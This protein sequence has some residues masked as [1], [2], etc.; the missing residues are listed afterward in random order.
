[1]A[2]A[3]PRIIDIDATSVEREEATQGLPQRDRVETTHTKESESAVRKSIQKVGGLF[4]T[5]ADAWSKVLREI[6]DSSGVGS[7]GRA[8]CVQT[9]MQEVNEKVA[10]KQGGIVLGLLPKSLAAVLSELDRDQS[11]E[12]TPEEVASAI[13]LMKQKKRTWRR[14]AIGLACVLLLVFCCFSVVNF[15]LVS[16]AFDLAKE[17]RA[18]ND[19][20]LR[21]GNGVEHAL[22]GSSETQLLP[23]GRLVPRTANQVHN[24][25]SGTCRRLQ[26]GGEVEVDEVLTRNAPA[27][28]RRLTSVVPDQYLAEMK[29][30]QL[31]L[32]A[33]NETE[34]VL[35]HLEIHGFVR[36]LDAGS[37]CGS[38][39]HLR[40]EWGEITLD[41]T[42]V[43]L[44]FEFRKR[45]EEF[46][47]FLPV[48]NVVAS[49]T[50]RRLQQG[51][52][53]VGLFN[54][55]MDYEWNCESTAKPLENLQP[56]YSFTI[57]TLVWCGSSCRSTHFNATLPGYT[58][59]PSTSEWS[60]IEIVERVVATDTEMVSKQTL[61]NL[62]GV[63]IHSHTNF[64]A[65]QRTTV[66]TFT[67]HTLSCVNDTD[68]GVLTFKD[69]DKWAIAALGRTEFNGEWF[70]VFNVFLKDDN[71]KE[72]VR[73]L[74]TVELWEHS[75]TM[76]PYK[77]YMPH[78][79]EGTSISYFTEFSKD[80]DAEELLTLK[81]DILDDCAR[82]PEVNSTLSKLGGV[83]VLDE[84]LPV[85]LLYQE[86]FD[87]GMLEVPQDRYW[88]AVVDDARLRAGRRLA[89]SHRRRASIREKN[90]LVSATDIANCPLIFE[91]GPFNMKF[92]EQEEVAVGG[93]RIRDIF[94]TA[95]G[96]VD[97]NFGPV[98]VSIGGQ[99]T[100]KTR[101]KVGADHCYGAGE[102]ELDVS[103][104]VGIGSL[105][106]AQVGGKGKLEA[107]IPTQTEFE[108]KTSEFKIVGSLT[109]YGSVDVFGMIQIQIPA[110]AH[111]VFCFPGI[112]VTL[113]RLGPVPIDNPTNRGDDT[114]SIAAK[115]T[116]EVN[117]FFFKFTVSVPITVMP[118]TTLW[119]ATPDMY[120]E[121]P[122]FTKDCQLVERTYDRCSAG[123][124]WLPDTYDENT[125]A[126]QPHVR[127]GA[128]AYPLVSTSA[129]RDFRWYCYGNEEWVRFPRPVNKIVAQLE[130][131]DRRIIWVGLVCDRFLE[132][133]ERWHYSGR[134][135]D[136]CRESIH[137]STTRG[138]INVHKWHNA[139]IHTGRFSENGFD[140][141][142][143]GNSRRR[144]YGHGQHYSGCGKHTVV[145]VRWQDRRRS[146]AVRWECWDYLGLPRQFSA[147]CM[148]SSHVARLF[149][150]KGVPDVGSDRECSAL[151]AADTNCWY[152]TWYPSGSCFFSNEHQ[153]AYSIQWGVRFGR[154]S[155]N[156]E[157]TLYDWKIQPGQTVTFQMPE[158]LAN[159]QVTVSTQGL[160]RSDT[161][162]LEPCYND[163]SG[164]TYQSQC[165]GSGTRVVL[166]LYSSSRSGEGKI[167]IKQAIVR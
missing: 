148:I 163:D 31:Q 20:V 63:E 6:S 107:E 1:M 116:V 37:Q 153:S 58:L 56:P 53:I 47:G 98:T 122:W 121:Q 144:G 38:V 54:F 95:G 124:I 104:G 140:W 71:V 24:C 55:I 84:K 128:E 92:C 76:K 35:Q 100:A 127:K 101:C 96:S 159:K 9:M 49:G 61:P 65:G 167:S 14:L 21:V 145:K 132:P 23:D 34:P 90:E 93:D 8:Q 29:G 161:V 109:P 117:F 51:S 46:F 120:G 160:S 147:E 87:A 68:D 80:V 86:L 105:I 108:G 40:T 156:C 7:D 27:K 146:G 94:V 164:G 103:I 36:K 112:E 142:C 125:G 60:Y 151:C 15:F 59:D 118:E 89:A 67:N 99:G 154:P 66:K 113:D 149:S 158:S 17:V 32:R 141:W 82:P 85:V 22:V 78:Q 3:A 52:S 165:S 42:D 72:Q 10:S 129:R 11:G 157:A 48:D 91:T 136:D 16:Y 25:S 131:N 106:N 44:S 81:E 19:G 97:A 166:K 28:E 79:L 137:V 135:D 57:R 74:A 143:N 111:G 114:I 88:K 64:A 30:I 133:H 12:I 119:S 39:V 123:H 83:S 102:V 2:Q 62:P 75:E 110:C 115:W 162:I 130:N 70:R 155:Y 150:Y 41:D 26:D 73:K 33:S 138:W 18:G 43:Y 45:A 139:D 77:F 4:G 13:D 152:W 126:W 69:A 50:T 5:L 134:T